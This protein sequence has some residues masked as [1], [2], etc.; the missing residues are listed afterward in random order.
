[1]RLNLGDF[2]RRHPTHRDAVCFG[3]LVQFLE[4]WQLIVIRCDDHLAADLV[5]QIILLA[6][7][8]HCL[9]ALD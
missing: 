2:G 5:G 1:M 3:P 8:E 4:L 7:S 9:A 6:K